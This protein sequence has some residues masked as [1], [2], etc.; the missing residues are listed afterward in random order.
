V[1]LPFP[2]EENLVRLT[3]RTLLAYLDDTLEPSE[4]KLIGQKVAESDAAQELIARI[5]QVTRRRRLTTPPTTGPN[6]FEPNTVAEYLDNTLP[7]DQVAEVEKACLESDVHLAEIA[8]A[9]QILTLVI[10]QPALVPPTARQRMYALIQGRKARRARPAAAAT[11]NGA[12][13]PDADARA[14]EDET[15]LMGLPF[16]RRQAAMRWL[17]PVAAVLLVAVLG[18]V[19]WQSLRE[20]GNNGTPVA[21]HNPNPNPNPEPAPPEPPP[22]DNSTKPPPP[23]PE[24]DPNKPKQTGGGE[25]TGGVGSPGTPTT[26]RQVVRPDPPSQERRD[27]GVFS[28]PVLSVLVSRPADAPA[29][30]WQRLKEKA[31]ISTKDTLVSL[32]GYKSDLVLDSGV[33]LTLWGS[34]YE[35]LSPYLESAVVL[36]L[37]AQGIDADFTLDRGAVLITNT[38]Q[39]EKA[40]VRIRF[41]GEVWDVAFEEPDTEVGVAILGRH[42]LPYGSGEPPRADGILMLRK[43]RASVRVSPW[44]E[45]GNLEPRKE[46]RRSVPVVIFWDSVGKGAQH[47][48]PYP[49]DPRMQ[50]QVGV[51]E[52]PLQRSD[53]AEE[54]IQQRIKETKAALDGMDRRLNGAGKIEDMLVEMLRPEELTPAGGL[55]KGVL[56]VRSLGALD[57][58][59]DLINVLD[60]SEKPPAL[61]AEA[62]STLRHWIGRSAGQENRLYDPKTRSGVLTEGG[63]LT[64]S[65]AA[66]FVELLHTPGDE[67][68]NSPAFW[69]YLI[70]KLKHEKLA[71]REL[72][73]FH[74]RRWVPES[75]MI[76]YNTAAEPEARLAGYKMWKDF[77]PDGKL[78]PTHTWRRE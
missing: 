27:V 64:P 28:R 2:T 72:A 46:G 8:A 3:L 62:I 26:V 21:V 6:S 75:P 60:D 17:L 23:P 70:D 12:P 71:I 31:H 25:I 4:T 24:T 11:T 65:E 50:S 41:Q 33:K 53:I 34:T 5:K 52:D 22:P 32:P 18:V 66:I 36:H 15:L 40:Q 61:R 9:H 1:G 42:V 77:I 51:F 76:R 30:S 54:D 44:V 45:Y 39:K 73:Y 10:G 57:S 78:P 63:K 58:V 43:G 13:I 69:A 59:K 48:V 20:G 55:L 49:T 67:Q 38:N 7:P 37:P 35:F 14:E 56:A 47:P 29:E 68:L 74:L 16:Y 19:L